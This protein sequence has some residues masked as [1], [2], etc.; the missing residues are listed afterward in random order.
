MVLAPEHPLVQM[1]TTPDQRDSVERYVRE[2][3]AKTAVD[4]QAQERTGVFTGSYAINPLS[5][6]RVPVWIGDYVLITY[7]TGAIMAVPAHDERDFDFAKRYSLPI[8]VVVSPPGWSGGERSQAYTGHG[9]LTASGQFDGMESDAAA[10]AIISHLEGKGAGSRKVTYKL[11]DWLIS[12]QR[13]WGTPIPIVHCSSCGP[14]AVPEDQLPVELPYVEDFRPTGTEK[15]PLANVDAFV[16][17]T[18]PQCGEPAQRETDVCDTFLDSSW[19]FLRY[20]STEFDDRPFDEARTRQWLPVTNYIGGKEHS[21]LHLLYSRFVTMALHDMGFLEFEEPF[22]RFRGHGLLILRGAKISKSRG[23]IVNPDDYF[24][25]HGADTLRAYLMFSGRYEEG[26]DFS[27]QGIE[28]VSRFLYRV[29]DLVQRFKEANGPGDEFP[30]DAQRSMHRTI[31]KVGEDIGDLKFNTA[32]AALMEYANELQRRDRLT[33]EETRTLLLLLAPLCPFVTEELWEQVGGEFSIHQQ[34]WPQFDQ[35]L[36]KAQEV[37]VAVQID[38]KT[39]DTFSIEAGAT[40]EEVLKRAR[41]LPRVERHLDGQ[42][43]TRAIFVQDR[44]VNF[45]TK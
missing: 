26:G 10:R 11:R 24:E 20:P 12:R 23:N 13:Y 28:G 22:E 31:R 3:L 32:V 15:A 37:T 14:V 19:Y 45:V 4:R 34:P 42:S 7:G 27:D 39:R 25:S 18:C 41:A 16:N 30:I 36:A 35:H 9:T 17:T 29:W 40:Q 44:L 33:H 38:G 8:K 21:V 1:L 2:A 5:G 6:E 43:V